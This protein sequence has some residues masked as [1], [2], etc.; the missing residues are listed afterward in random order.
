MWGSWG[1]TAL[2]CP[3]ACQEQLLTRVALLAAL[4]AGVPPALM[5]KELG[6]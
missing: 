1:S 2:A 6:Q 3:G 4:L 5:V